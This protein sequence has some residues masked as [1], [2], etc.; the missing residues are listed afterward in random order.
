MANNFYRSIDV[1]FDRFEVKKRFFSST[2]FY[3]LDIAS[4]KMFSA[5]QVYVKNNIFKIPANVLLPE[6]KVREL[7]S[8]VDC[9]TEQSCD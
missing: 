4:S 7:R 3:L 2:N 6:D 8:E 1:A 9:I 5:I